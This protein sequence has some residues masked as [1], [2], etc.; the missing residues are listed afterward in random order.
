MD[1]LD[2]LGGKSARQGLLLTTLVSLLQD[3]GGLSALVGM[4]D[5]AGLA[6]I[7]RS[8]IGGGAN[9][10]VSA[11]QVMAA[12]GPSGGNILGDLAS[13]AGTDE[14]ETANDLSDILP[15]AVDL[16]SPKGSVPDGPLGD[17]AQSALGKLFG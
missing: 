10:P 8:W 2:K 9:A 6:D 14:R 13:R 15:K 7:A 3:R 5:K 17:L 4:F 11:A 1:F 16:L 12:L